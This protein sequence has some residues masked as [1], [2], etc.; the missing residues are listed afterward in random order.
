LPCNGGTVEEQLGK[1]TIAPNVLVTIVQKTADSVPGVAKLCENIPGV[2]RLLGLNTVGQGVE[3]NVVDD[4]VS[5]DIYLMAKRDVDL[6]Q[7]GRQLQHQVTRA[8]HDIVG[9]EVREVNIHIEDVATEL[10]RSADMEK[11]QVG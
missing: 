11:A 10:A 2:K 6:L 3:V 8:I 9:M 7:M 1:V 5:V 4:Q